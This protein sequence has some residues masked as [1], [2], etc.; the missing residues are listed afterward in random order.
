MGLKVIGG[1]GK[2]I[3]WNE[4]EDLVQ[5]DINS[6]K[7]QRTAKGST[8]LNVSDWIYRGQA[9]SNWKLLTTLERY[10]EDELG[11]NSQRYPVKKYLRY[12]NA[13]VPALNTL[14][15]KTHQRLNP[16]QIAEVDR[17]TL[18]NLEYLCFARHLGFP[19]PLLDWTFSYYVAAFFAFKE[20]KPNDDVAIYAFKEWN[21]KPRSGWISDPLM[22]GIGPYI[23]THERHYRQNSTYTICR[24]QNDEPDNL[25]EFRRH[26]DAIT[27]NP[28]NH[29]LKKFII[30]SS[31]RSIVLTKLFRMNINDY[32]LFGDEE[33][34]MRML[35]FKERHHL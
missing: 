14:S 21:G 15:Q 1:E 4:F 29:T 30:K 2:P 18:P 10:L 33:S 28:E 31:E 25:I 17:Y 20:A 16:E 23:E 35:A 11:I 19:S 32:T 7:E 24:S 9:N 27:S 8:A 6:V 3:T 5:T 12:I 13:T 22:D 26:E 34:L